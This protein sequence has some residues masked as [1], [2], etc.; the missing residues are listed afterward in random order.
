MNKSHIEKIGN[1]KVYAE[2]IKPGTYH[3]KIVNGN[4]IIADT[5]IEGAAVVSSAIESALTVYDYY[6]EKYLYI[7]VAGIQ[8]KTA[9]T[10]HTADKKG[11]FCRVD[12]TRF[13]KH[14]AKSENDFIKDNHGKRIIDY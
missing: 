14:F 6:T 1:L 3:I 5:I 9:N 8:K 4:S 7:H 11:W 10:Y 12:N 2:A 13:F